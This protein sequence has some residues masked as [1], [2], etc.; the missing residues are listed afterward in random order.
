MAIKAEPIKA[1]AIT[2]FQPRA[3]RIKSGSLPTEAV[4]V[5]L[6]PVLIQGEPLTI[7]K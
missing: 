2:G 4:T 1:R 7:S 3:S 6:D 5:Q